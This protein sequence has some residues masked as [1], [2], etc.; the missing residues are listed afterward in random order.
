MY[1]CYLDGFEVTM[2]EHI[3]SNSGPKFTKGEKCLFAHLVA[4][5]SLICLVTI[6]YLIHLYF[7]NHNIHEVFNTRRSNVYKNGR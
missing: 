4:T 5:F 3:E 2:N 1:S 6:L 7:V